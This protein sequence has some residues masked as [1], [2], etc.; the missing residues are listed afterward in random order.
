MP[1]Y[2]LILIPGS[3]GNG[4][5]GQMPATGLQIQLFPSHYLGLHFCARIKATVTLASAQTAP[6]SVPVT[7][8]AIPGAAPALLGAEVL[9]AGVDPFQGGKGEWPCWCLVGVGG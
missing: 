1:L 3:L 6:R 7:G 9:Y 2:C 4:T 8:S 5:L